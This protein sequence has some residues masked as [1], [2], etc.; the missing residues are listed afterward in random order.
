M[1]RREHAARRRG[2]AWPLASHVQQP[3]PMRRIGMLM[4]HPENDLEGELRATAS[5]K[6]S[7]SSAGSLAAIFRSIF[8][9][10][11]PRQWDTI[12]RRAAAA[13][14]AGRDPGQWH[15]AG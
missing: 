2:R 15:A 11:R 9:G 5:G 6:D 8:N 4:L 3:E 13:T 7:R 14:G 12:R 10:L 1:R